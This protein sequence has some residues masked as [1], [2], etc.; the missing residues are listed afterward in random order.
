M[1][2]ALRALRGML[3]QALLRSEANPVLVQH[4][5]FP[6]NGPSEAE[7][8]PSDVFTLLL[9]GQDWKEVQ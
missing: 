6:S 5:C 7:A 1:Y 4:R 2:S 8:G 3:P 9:S